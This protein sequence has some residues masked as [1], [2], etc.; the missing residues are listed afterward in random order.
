MVLGDNWLQ[1]HNPQINW[2]QRSVTFNSTDYFKR[3]CLQHGQPCTVYESGHKPVRSKTVGP[4]PDIEIQMVS[5]RAFFHLAR[6]KDHHGFMFT[7]KDDDEKHFC[8]ST[9]NAVTADNYDKFM[10]G[11]PTY[12]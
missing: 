4:K 1:E 12:I 2:K 3:G 10:K 8:A 11:K 7:P 5:A 9:T 6:K